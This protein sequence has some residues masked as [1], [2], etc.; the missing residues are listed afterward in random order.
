[1]RAAVKMESIE[2]RLLALG[3]TAAGQAERPLF[4]ELNP[5]R[6]YSP[7]LKSPPQNPRPA[8][9]LIPVLNRPQGHTVL[10]TVRSPTMPSHAGQI[11]FP[12]GGPKDGD[13][14]PV[15][16]A[17][18]EASEEVGL[19]ADAVEVASVFGEHHG[20]LGYRV[21]PVVGI[22]R[23]PPEIRICTREVDEAFE[24]PLSFLTDLG[25]HIVIDKAFR[26]IDYRMYAIP[27][28]DAGTERHI[29]GLT[30]GILHTLAL[31]WNG[32]PVAP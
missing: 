13:Q 19:P 22:V 29:W 2:D 14:G 15:E 11:S 18:R 8:S 7:I 28:D 30:A 6:D 4:H 26:G 32:Q 24:V 21:T 16:T 9:V 5:D 3:R 23:T 17:L 20:G 12:G 1:M 25:N 10:F 31:A 27:Y